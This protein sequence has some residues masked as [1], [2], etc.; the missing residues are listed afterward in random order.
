MGA[1]RLMGMKVR[2]YGCCGMRG[3][4]VQRVGWDCKESSLSGRDYVSWQARHP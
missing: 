2:M 4:G 1:D 3:T